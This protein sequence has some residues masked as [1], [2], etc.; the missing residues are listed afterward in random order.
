M[1]FT[2]LYVLFLFLFGC[3]ETVEVQ[4]L[5][6]LNGYWEI[7]KVVFPD[8]SSKEYS[9]STTIDFIEYADLQGFRKKV[10]PNLNGTFNTSDDAEFFNII[11]KNDIFIIHYANELS[12]WEETIKVLSKSKLV[13]V[14]SESIT[15]H[16]KRFEGQL[17]Q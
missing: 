15:Y 10:Q 16:Y 6:N 11:P 17:H 5:N 13:V 9:I 3:A 12:S 14:N 4:D 2:A 1:R 8:G 7:Q